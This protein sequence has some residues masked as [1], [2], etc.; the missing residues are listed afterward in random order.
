MNTLKRLGPLALLT[1]LAVVV[2]HALL[3][4]PGEISHGA[5]SDLA[6]FFLPR[7][8]WAVDFVKTTG[9]LP[10]WDSYTFSGMPF[11]GNMQS[12]GW[13]PP[14]WFGLVLPPWMFFNL[15]YVAHA[16]GAG[17]ACYALARRLGMSRAAAAFVAVVYQ[18]SGFYTAHVYAGHAAHMG[19]YPWLPLQLLAAHEMVRSRRA[20]WS[21]A[22]AATGA[23]QLIS[24]HPQFFLYSI[25]FVA[26]FA[27]VEWWSA[28][29]KKFV[30]TAA[31]GIL[32]VA[33]LFGLAAVVF[34]PGMEFAGLMGGA[35]SA[36][37]GYA[38]SF[39]IAPAD[40]AR[41]LFGRRP[42]LEMAQ[43]PIMWESCGY[44]GMM[45]LAL[46]GAG[47][48]LGRKKT[49]ERFL[50]ISAVCAVLFATGKS[51]YL[52]Y[53]FYYVVPGY[54]TFRAPA[55]MLMVFTMAVSLLAGLGIDGLLALAAPRKK[56]GLAFAGCVAGAVVAMTLLLRFGGP[57]SAAWG[58]AAW[59]FRKPTV[60]AAF[61]LMLGGAAACG[62]RLA[63]AGWIATAAVAFDLAAFGM[64]LVQTIPFDKL[65]WPSE[66][67]KR[68]ASDKR[69]FRVIHYGETIMAA[70]LTRARIEVVQ[71][72]YDASMLGH[73]EA[74]SRGRRASLEQHPDF[75]R[76][77]NV[78][79]M[80]CPGR[81]KANQFSLVTEE[82]APG[83]GVPNALMR[84]ED[85]TSRVFVV[86]CTRK[87]PPETPLVMALAKTELTRE[88]LVEQDEALVSGEPRHIEGEVTSYEPGKLA[89]TVELDR[90]GYLVVS[91]I[92]HPGWRIYENGRALPVYRTDGALLGTPLGPGRHDVRIVYDPASIRIGRMASMI[93]LLLAVVI[94]AVSLRGKRA[95]TG[96]PS[97]PKGPAEDGES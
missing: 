5:S 85:F 96:E 53:F 54:A 23:I 82:P 29:R 76:L 33:L 66:I 80:I 13:Y 83:G 75:C 31:L 61:V 84:F 56:A 51:G 92:W 69:P 35:R 38:R 78:R 6:Q 68:V 97:P 45:T 89:A 55:R 27:I 14:N 1:A 72:C 16:L 86:G 81:R 74:L 63:G 60:I 87:R 70:H 47:F 71:R 30:K 58:D 37:L 46:A 65:L 21:V 4:R 32:A 40:V 25:T 91:E 18:T 93:S 39:S 44:V 3:F 57:F 77:L 11:V 94:S 17:L 36:P 79:Y 26:A 73:F 10:L 43:L 41:L 90:A 22:L 88:A 8:L 28:G 49:L 7:F 24:G 12:P 42:G 2:Y 52:Y 20:V 34:L 19:N 15:Y 59:A 48:W 95:G 67:V 64:P 62:F 50:A 9:R